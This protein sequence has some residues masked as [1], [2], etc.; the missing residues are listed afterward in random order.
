MYGWRMLGILSVIEVKKME[1]LDDY[2]LVNATAAVHVIRRFYVRSALVSC[3]EAVL[4]ADVR[5]SI[6]L[7]TLSAEV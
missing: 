6:D 5:R 2:V 1:C 7:F 4:L 3:L